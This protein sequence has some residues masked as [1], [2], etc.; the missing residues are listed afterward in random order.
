MST[1]NGT[2][3]EFPLIRVDYFH[4]L[5]PPSPP[6]LSSLSPPP[7]PQAP[8]ACFLSHIHTDHLKGLE[9][10][11]SPFVYCTP[12]TR[13]LLLRLER[14]PHRLNFARG[15]LETRKRTYGH[16]K[17][18]LRAVPLDVPTRIE[19]RPG[20]E[21]RVTAVEAN[22][23]PGACMFLFESVDVN[24][25]GRES[26]KARGDGPVGTMGVSSH[27]RRKAVL[28]TG[29]VRAEKWWVESLVRHPVL[30]P[31]VVGT[32]GMRVELGEGKG[33]KQASV[34]GPARSLR[35]LDKIYLDTSFA[36]K[37]GEYWSFEPKVKG[38][39]EMLCKVQQEEVRSGGKTRY[40][41]HAWT[42]GYEDVLV[43]LS[44]FLESR[45][46][47]DA[48]RWKLYN[49]LLEGETR[50]IREAAKLVG[51]R[52]GNRW[53]DGCLTSEDGEDVRI[54]ACEKGMGCE[55]L[56]DENVVQI[57][58][59]VTRYKGVEYMETGVGGGQGDL[60]QVHELELNDL[61]TIGALIELCQKRLQ[62]QPEVLTKVMKWLEDCVKQGASNVKL[63]TEAFYDALEDGSQTR[64]LDEIPI[65]RLVGALERL[66]SKKKEKTELPTKRVT[67]PYSRHASYEE[68]RWL[69]AAF[70]PKAVYPNT[71][72]P[73]MDM[74]DLFGDLLLVPTSK[75]KSSELMPEASTPADRNEQ[76][77]QLPRAQ[78]K[79]VVNDRAK[80]TPKS[81]PTERIDQDL[82]EKQRASKDGHDRSLYGRTEPTSTPFELKRKRTDERASLE[83]ERSIQRRISAFQ[84][85]LSS[86][87]AEFPGLDLVSVKGYHNE[88]K[89][90]EL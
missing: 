88:E 79:D 71:Y 18:V 67:F 9:S 68:L 54:H 40:Y 34:T 15:I 22:H 38:V 69:V 89:E 78:V 63:D 30:G 48:Y 3:P 21:I 29:D 19:L 20:E 10:L 58:P 75:D 86:D 66:V 41:F 76:A 39:R 81:T 27:G 59:I 80:A 5:A 51:F 70:R 52:E 87:D 43:A 24:D 32:F 12:A 8:L 57:V 85:V 62:A 61:N 46:H 83:V 36:V 23:C 82:V 49:A 16:L 72:E 28:Y 4:A 17:R 14:Y 65:E 35:T 84:S 55:V 6:S 73:G 1:F 33:D 31:Y 25:Q 90:V 60:D 42:A 47:V 64:D 37:R 74:D 7:P 45:V 13:S 11:R 53:Q 44:A 26:G 50:D 77:V 56:K 2:I